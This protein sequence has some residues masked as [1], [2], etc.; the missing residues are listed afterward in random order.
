[1][2]LISASF[3]ARTRLKAELPK[4]HKYFVNEQYSRYTY[5][6][7]AKVVAALGVDRAR[8]QERFALAGLKGAGSSGREGSKSQSSDE[9]GLKEL[10]FERYGRVEGASGCDEI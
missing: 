8:L 4:P 7:D 9:G 10:H 5:S 6:K 3:I 2:R 1:M